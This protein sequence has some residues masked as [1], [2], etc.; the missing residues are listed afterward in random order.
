VNRD[1]YRIDRRKFL[2]L[3][4]LGLAGL[5]STQGGVERRGVPA[6]VK[7]AGARPPIR[8]ENRQAKS[9][10][11]FVLNNG[12]I[13]EKPVIDSVLGG[14]ALFDFDNDGFVDIFFTNGAQIP[15]LEKDGPTFFNRLYKNNRDGTFTDVTERAGVA[16]AGYSMGVAAADYDNDGWTDLYVTGVNRNFLYHNNGDGTF[17]D[18]TERA[19]VAGLDA[20]GKK[21][22]SVGAIWLDY[23][24]DGH[25]D[26]FVAN[27]LDW[28]WA[29][30]KV[31]G[32]RGKRLSCS[33]LLYGGLP[34][35][36]YHNNGDGTFTDVSESSG[37]SRYV[38]KGM[39]LAMA[40][41]DGDGFTDIFV[42][43]DVLGNF[44]F[45][46]LN[47]KSF[48]EVAIEAV[49][50]YTEDGLPISNMGVDFR[51]LNNDGRPDLVITSL[52]GDMF[53]LYLN[54]GQGLFLPSSFQAGLGYGTLKMSGWGVGAY[55]LDN[56]GNKDVF[57]ANSHV[58]ENADF[59]GHDRYKQSNAVFLN[60][61]NNRF[62]NV[63]A[64]AGPAMQVAA[65][66]RG[67]AFG[68]LNNDGRIDVVGSVIGEPAELLYNTSAGENHWILIQ[69]EGTKSNRDGIGT[70]IKLTGESG[71]VQYNHITTS[72][73]Y[74][75]SSDKRVHF[76]LGADRRIREIE[77]RWPSGKVQV[78][79]DVAAD[80][81][82]KVKEE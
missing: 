14:V 16:G 43:N 44:L 79:R 17:T 36:L 25:L 69:A 50:A 57:T 7:P 77:L 46:N 18:V 2:Q 62:R 9:G 40:D 28:S 47:G 4:G 6:T 56:D 49:V 51:D 48:T 33:P 71:R 11:D 64:Q 82:L 72:V 61:G 31:C 26:L 37:I 53:Q 74:V 80:Q 38:G 27:Y 54:M 13:P 42:G 32:D 67:C 24:N 58:S 20:K 70:K 78:V 76:G 60:L 12:T 41:Y 55:D 29:S 73:G 66:H 15:S 63:T 23:D 75:S 35:I 52:E 8:F 59:Y 81:I 30:S 65:A 68:D 45:K 39:G 10:L 5:A 21:L 1:I 34:N 3:G 22:W 19:G